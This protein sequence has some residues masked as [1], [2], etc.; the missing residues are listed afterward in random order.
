ML[1]FLQVAAASDQGST[2]WALKARNATKRAFDNGANVAVPDR[3]Q[4]WRQRSVGLDW[5]IFVAVLGF[6]D[7]QR[8]ADRCLLQKFRDV[9]GD[10]WERRFRSCRS[11]EA[12][13][14]FLGGS[15]VGVR[16]PTCDMDAS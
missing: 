14:S 9:S 12:Q 3:W 1:A 13:D 8:T 4:L 6:G 2:L 10:L 16:S 7:P 15:R 5:P 11:V